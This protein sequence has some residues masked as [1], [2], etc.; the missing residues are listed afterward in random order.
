MNREGNLF[1]VQR[2]DCNVFYVGLSLFFSACTL[3]FVQRKRSG[4]KERS[5]FRSQMSEVVPH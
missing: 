2:H 3:Y 1:E 5:S 4:E